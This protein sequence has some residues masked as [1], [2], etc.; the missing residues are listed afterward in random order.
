MLAA[1]FVIGLV[2]GIALLVLGRIRDGDE[3]WGGILL[4]V[5]FAI[6]ML[7]WVIEY[8]VSCATV[9]DLETFW[10]VERYNYEDAIE[11]YEKGANW[12]SEETKIYDLVGM[13]KVLSD[14]TEKIEYYNQ[15]LSRLRSFNNNIWLDPM[16]KDVPEDL[17]YIRLGR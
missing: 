3:F 16:Y 1:I 10:R 13:A 14:F 7:V 4:T 2:C 6:C 11:S 15:E 9:A 12:L 8:S 5:I 17:E